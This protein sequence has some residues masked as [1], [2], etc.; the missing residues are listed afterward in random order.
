MGYKEA[1]SDWHKEPI[2]GY[3]ITGYKFM[4]A[5]YP[6]ILVETGIVGMLAFFWLIYALF[7]VGINTWRSAPN[8]LMRGL[9]VG[10]TAGL[11]G[12][13]LHAVGANTFILVRIMEPFWF[14]VGIVIV[15]ASAQEDSLSEPSV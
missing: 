4:D 10:L 14:L 5:Q 12:L 2:L 7:Q 15:L 6:R 13:L 1:L 3:G 11:L 8:D 9:S